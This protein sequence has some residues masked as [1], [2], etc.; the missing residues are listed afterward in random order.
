VKIGSGEAPTD[1]RLPRASGTISKERLG[2]PVPC[3]ASLSVS[4]SVSLTLDAGRDV[5]PSASACWPS[6]PP[7]RGRV[8]D[9]PAAAERPEA[10]AGSERRGAGACPP[11]AQPER[12]SD[13]EGAPPTRKRS[14]R[15]ER[16]PCAAVV[17]S[18]PLVEE[19]SA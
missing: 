12:Q 10:A 8:S 9:R 4:K 5:H 17:A 13:R 18:T 14:E 6:Q 11:T 19:G 1:T 15:S 3:R 16:V 7:Q 2:G